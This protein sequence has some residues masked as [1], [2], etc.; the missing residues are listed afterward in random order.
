MENEVLT[1]VRASAVRRG[2]GVGMLGL[3]GAILVY[4]AVTRPPAVP[5][6][7]GFLALVGLL[8]LFGALA[9]WRATSEA[10]ELT[11]AGLRSTSGEVIAP[12]E[13]IE[14]VDRGVFAFK[15]SNGFILRLK[16]AA[17]GRWRPGLWWRLG[18][19]VGVGGVTPGAQGKAM[20][21]TLTA[22]LIER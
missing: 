1:V 14:S 22:L 15:P 3:L 10:V 7:Q 16:S 21:D 6:W 13:Q 2:L 18:R 8:A 12:L 4:L 19:R 11:R 5:A 17:P 20:A 9:M